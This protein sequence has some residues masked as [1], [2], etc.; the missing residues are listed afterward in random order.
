MGHSLLRT[1]AFQIG[2][3]ALLVFLGVMGLR[4]EGYLERAELDA[5]DWSLRLRPTKARLA[6]PVTLV[7]ITDKDIRELGHWPVTDEILAKALDILTQHHP[8]T[9]GVDI[10]RDLEVPPGRQE[11]D[12]VLSAH[13]EM[14]MVMKFGEIEKGGIPGP[15]IL[16]GTDRVGFSDVVV[17][18]DGIVRRGLLYLDDETDFYRSFSLLLALQYLKAEGIVPVPAVENP[19]WV[20]L[21]D[22]VFRHFES[23]DGSY[24]EADAQGYQF[25]L[26][27]D[28]GKNVFPSISFGAVLAGNFKPELFQDRI[29]LIGVM[30]QGVKDYFYTSQCET[31]TVCPPIPGIE[32]HGYMVHQLLRSA[33]EKGYALIATFSDSLEAGWIGLW[34]LG[35]GFIGAYVRGAWRFSL[36]VLMGI[37]LLSGVVVGGMMQGKWVPFIPPVLGWMVNAMVV[38]ALISNREKQDRAVLMSLF[39]RHVSPQVAQAVWAQ[40]DQFLENGRLRP[41]KLVVTTLFSDIEGFTPVAESMEPHKLLDWLNTYLETMVTII[42]DHGGVVDDYYGDMIKADFGVLTAGQTEE[43]IKREA[44]NAVRCAMTME[45]E[46]IRLNAQWQ[47][48]GLPAVRMRIG[49]N[50]GPVVAGSLGSA[51]RLKFTT[52]GDSV[53]IAARLESFKKDSLQTWA[54]EEVCRI[55]IGEMTKHYLGDHPWGLKEVG[56]VTLKGKANT[57]PVYRLSSQKC[58]QDQ[59]PPMTPM[60]HVIQ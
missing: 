19:D 38:T 48:E 54:E 4:W 30:A 9:I 17:D 12:R 52:V 39:S 42:A 53:N 59:I 26:D 14:I 5:Y 18:F 34:V 11:L 23:H 31:L 57:I 13:P 27:L 10:Y 60:E 36:A 43:D 21:G 3:I 58:G 32:L 2:V 28:R 29:V 22:T 7:A 16:R 35:G 6:P 51:Q 8:R 46:M 15:A 47:Q 37:L 44:K 49:I 56:A 40:R 20:Q 33:Q 45:Q 55:L 24:I 1:P 25:L 50:T 41:Q